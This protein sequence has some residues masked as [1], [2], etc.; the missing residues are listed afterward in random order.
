MTQSTKFTDRK[1]RV[2]ELDLDLLTCLEIDK[3]D[4]SSLDV[5]EFSMLEPSQELYKAIIANTRLMFAIIWVIVQKQAIH[6]YAA[7]K[8]LPDEQKHHIEAE[9]YAR[10][11][12]AQSFFPVDP[13]APFDADTDTSEAEL[14]F[15]SG[16]SGPV[17]KE[18]RA[19]FVEALANFFPQHR[20]ALS[21]LMRQVERT[22]NKINQKI[23]E[24]EPELE[25]LMDQEMEKGIRS[26]RE[27]LAKGQ[28]SEA[29][30]VS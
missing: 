10:K 27:K 23:E 11:P 14:E 15:V 28:G 1:G 24:T 2:W 8:A 6:Y 16:I 30:T 13:K 26:L 22:T 9:W 25:K 3:T 5:P 20:T 18:A 21:T 4:F 17:V 19:A 12:A 7:W 29:T